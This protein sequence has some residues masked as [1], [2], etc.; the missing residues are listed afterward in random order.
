MIKKVFSI[1]D[2]QTSIYNLP[3]FQHTHGEAERTVRSMLE[4][5]RTM[6]A[7]FP[8]HFDLF[9]LGEFD[10]D[11]GKFTPLDTPQHVIK[12]NSLTADTV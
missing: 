1:R 3:F 6:P 11:S 2:S 7:Q 4:D 8:D 9:F 5:K 12:L 10:D